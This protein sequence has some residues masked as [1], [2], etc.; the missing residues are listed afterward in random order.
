MT[1]IT[2]QE[3]NEAMV[4]LSREIADM[5]RIERSIQA[6]IKRLSKSDLPEYEAV[7]E[8]LTKAEE[9]F[10][11]ALMIA[12]DETDYPIWIDPTYGGVYPE[13]STAKPGG[14]R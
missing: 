6:K 7:L 3:Y 11:T 9:Y 5:E 8:Y 14:M 10:G 13:G 12:H 1:K 2:A 4:A